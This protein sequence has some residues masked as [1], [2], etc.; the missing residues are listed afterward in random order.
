M[1]K[2]LQLPTVVFFIAVACTIVWQVVHNCEP[3]YQGKRLS[4]WLESLD[5]PP[6]RA[7]FEE[8]G[9]YSGWSDGNGTAVKEA[10]RHMGQ[11][12]VPALRRM[13]NYRDNPLKLKLMALARRQRLITFHIDDVWVL[14]YRAASACR[15]AEP[16]VRTQLVGDWIRLLIDTQAG[17]GPNADALFCFRAAAIG[18]LGSEAREP[19]IQALTNANAQLRIYAAIALVQFG[20]PSDPDVQFT[21]A[22]AFNRMP[23]AIIPALQQELSSNSASA[24]RWSLIALGNFTNEAPAIVPAIVRAL[25]DKD[26]GVRQEATNVLKVI[27]SR[28]RKPKGG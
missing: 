10:L 17:V 12:V 4:V 20:L 24:R 19:L 9:W 16:T 1:R 21:A 22:E 14:H 5:D 3:V 27:D 28:G 18:N 25:E 6:G 11:K 2:G 26:A 23:P 7:S 8:H 15:L 13:V